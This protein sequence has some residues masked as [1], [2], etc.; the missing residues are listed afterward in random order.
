MSDDKTL[1]NN[2]IR[3]F[4]LRI[5]LMGDPGAD[6]SLL[7]KELSGS[8]ARVEKRQV[9]H[10][11]FNFTNT[12]SEVKPIEQSDYVLISESPR[13]Q[14]TFSEPQNAFYLE[15]N[16]YL[17]NSIYKDFLGKLMD[18]FAR[19]TWKLNSRRIGLRYINNFDCDSEKQI[20]KI[21]GK[22]FSI[23]MK[24]MLLS[25]NRNRIIC[26]EECNNNGNKLRLQYGIPNKY[27]PANITNYDLLLD[28]DSYVEANYPSDEWC[29]VIRGLNHAAYAVFID[30]LNPKYLESLK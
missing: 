24:H 4:I 10:I 1:A 29:E 16:Q 3:S 27:Y 20:Q 18:V 17:N 14:V 11:Q 5:D 21:Y 25:E 12:K 26:V 23:I 6:F 19:N 13:Y 8:F 15:S 9:Q 7:V 2:A 22:R 28:I 30:A